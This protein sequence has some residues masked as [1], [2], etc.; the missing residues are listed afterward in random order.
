VDLLKGEIANY[1]QGSKSSQFAEY[2][3]NRAVLLKAKLQSIVAAELIR[4]D[5]NADPAT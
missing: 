3:E 2:N 5:S 1:E 4:R